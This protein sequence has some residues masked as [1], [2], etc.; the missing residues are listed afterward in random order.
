MAEGAVWKARASVEQRGTG[1]IGNPIKKVNAPE[2]RRVCL[3]ASLFVSCCRFP[4]GS[5]QVWGQLSWS[6]CQALSSHLVSPSP[7]TCFYTEN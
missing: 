5:E 3:F 4:A 7:L 6:R 2:A 1:S